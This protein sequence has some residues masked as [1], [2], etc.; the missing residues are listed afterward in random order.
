MRLIHSFC[1]GVSET[2]AALGTNCNLLVN[3]LFELGDAK[4][5]KHLCLKM[6]NMYNN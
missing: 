2:Q 6:Y 4:Y 5:K 1:D 3:A